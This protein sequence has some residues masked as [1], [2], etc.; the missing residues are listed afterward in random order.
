MMRSFIAIVLLPAL[1]Q[2]IVGQARSPRHA[3]SMATLI[4]VGAS[5]QVS[6]SRSDEQ[7]REV[8]LASDP[9][10]SSHLLACS[11]FYPK[12]PS[13][14]N[15]NNVAIVAYASFDGGATWQETLNFVEGPPTNMASDPSCAFGTGG[16][17]YLAALGRDLF[18]FR[19]TDSGKTWDKPV[20]LGYID[21]E[22]LTVDNTHGR[23]NGRV[24]LHGTGAVM[25]IDAGSRVSSLDL[26]RS[27]DKAATFLGPA[28]LAAT[29]VG[30]SVS[31]MG[32]GVVLPDGTFVAI[33]RETDRTQSNFVQTRPYKPVGK[34]IT[35]SS[36]DGGTTFAKPAPV[37]DFYIDSA[38][39]N[40]GLP[41]L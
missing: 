29:E 26:L 41:V 31:S 36:E 15:P 9:E 7:H 4:S 3:K 6:K 25:P 1:L 40:R 8:L 37:S 2:N 32:N 23:Y 39:A 22:Y 38:H 33:A 11:V 12:P 16:V 14:P 34:T 20:Q 13:P 10:D 18:V 35:V 27:M 28:K 21:R 19:S 5:V 30:H 24:Y 17:A